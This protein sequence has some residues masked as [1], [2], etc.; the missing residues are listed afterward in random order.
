MMDRLA[1]DLGP[2]GLRA[3]P[4]PVGSD[5]PVDITMSPPAAV[6]LVWSRDATGSQWLAKSLEAVRTVAP[7]PGDPDRRPAAALD[8]GTAPEASTADGGSPAPPAYDLRV[9]STDISQAERDFMQ[10]LRPM[11]GRSPRSLTRYVNIFRLLKAVDRHT[12]AA[13]GSHRSGSEPDLDDATM[14]LLAVL[15]GYPD[16]A[17]PFLTELARPRTRDEHAALTAIVERARRRGRSRGSQAVPGSTPNADQWDHLLDWLSRH[18][19]WAEG[20]QIDTWGPMI[21]RVAR[22]SYRFDAIASAF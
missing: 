15:T 20:Q 12:Q 6:V 10:E 13:A 9:S 16:I 21:H 11:L 18:E 19:E 5:S 4:A 1:G 17:E 7:V 22:Y 14:F 3:T 8:T 2:W